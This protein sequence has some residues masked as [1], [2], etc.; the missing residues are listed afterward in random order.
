MKEE[1]I[2]N[3]GGVTPR[4]Y[5]PLVTLANRVNVIWRKVAYL[6]FIQRQYHAL[7]ERVDRLEQHISNMHKE[8]SHEHASR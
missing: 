3:R 7:S 2:E 6:W 1:R 8:T 5:D 4:H